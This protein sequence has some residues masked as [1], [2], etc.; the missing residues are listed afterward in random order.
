MTK[1]EGEPFASFYAAYEYARHHELELVCL[2]TTAFAKWQRIAPPGVFQ[3]HT[4]HSGKRLKTC[5]MY[6]PSL[7]PLAPA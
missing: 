1:V 6:P 2:G 5:G 4:Y 7:R 3:V